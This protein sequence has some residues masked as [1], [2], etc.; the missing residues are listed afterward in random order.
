MRVVLV[1]GSDVTD[2][3]LVHAAQ[4]GAGVALCGAKRLGGFGGPELSRRRVTCEV[5]D[6]LVK[7]P[8]LWRDGVPSIGVAQRDIPAGQEFV[9]VGM[10]MLSA[11]EGDTDVAPATTD[12]RE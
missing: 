6:R 1:F 8:R 5:C 12:E 7:N 11:I 10:D 2:A 9:S 3:G 4:P